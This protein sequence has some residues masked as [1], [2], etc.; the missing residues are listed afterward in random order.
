MT[1]GSGLDAVGVA[2]RVDAGGAEESMLGVADRPVSPVAASAVE[3]GAEEAALDELGAVDEPELGK[4]IG[5]AVGVP[6]TELHA[7]SAAPT[8][9]QAIARFLTRVCV[10]EAIGGLYRSFVRSDQLRDGPNRLASACVRPQPAYD[11]R[12]AVDS[13]GQAV[14]AHG[15]NLVSDRLTQASCARGSTQRKLPDWPK[16][17]KV[18]G[19]LFGLVQCGLL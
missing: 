7:L 3:I 12:T 11:R 5:A 4:V 10:R 18:S 6:E 19:L 15:P 16:W 14:L 13:R 9:T 1:A 8:T 2:G 17:P